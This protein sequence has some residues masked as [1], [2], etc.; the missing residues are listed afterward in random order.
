MFFS[1]VKALPI[2]TIDNGENSV[3]FDE[4]AES[5]AEKP[6]NVVYC[7]KNSM[8]FGIISTGDVH[9]AK[10]KGKSTVKVNTSFAYLCEGEYLK[11]RRIFHEDKRI[12]TLPILDEHNRLIGEHSRWDD[13]YS[14]YELKYLRGNRF[15]NVVLKRYNEVAIVAPSNNSDKKKKI[16]TEWVS[17][18]EEHDVRVE[19]ICKESVINCF[20]KKDIVFFFDENEMRGVGTLFKDVLNKD[21]RWNQVRTLRSIINAVEAVAEQTSEERI[22]R[23]FI[24]EGA[25]LFTIHINEKNSRY[26]KKFR[27]EIKT[28]YDSIGAEVNNTFHKEFRKNFYDDIYNEE[29]AFENSTREY[30]QI[31]S[32]GLIKLKDTQSKFYNVVGGERVT[33]GQPEGYNNTIWFFGPCFVIGAYVDDA[34]T[35]ESKLQDLICESG[36]QSRVVNCGSFSNKYQ[37]LLRLCSTE[38]RSGDIVIYHSYNQHRMIPYLDLGEMLE[39]Q[40]VSAKNFLNN[41]RHGNHK[42]YKL[43]A[44]EIYNY[45]PKYLFGSKAGDRI[46]KSKEKYEL[47]MAPYFE[48]FFKNYD[49]KEKTGAVVVNCNP[50]TYGHRYLIEEAS[51][52]V[53]VLIVFVVNEDASLF[54]FDERLAMVTEGT[55]DLSNVKVVPSGEFILSQHSFPEYF[56]KVVDDELTN[57]AEFDV[58]LFAKGVAPRLN[59]KYRFVGEEN[60]DET[61]REYNEAMKRILPL[62]GIEVIEIPRKKLEGKSYPIS[63]TIVRNRL[64]MGDWEGVKEFVP[65]STIS[66]IRCAD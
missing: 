32:D 27:D 14:F 4:I 31:F 56:N 61:T 23:A 37:S 54:S 39:Q 59:I 47:L 52:R 13:V 41:P 29:Y 17:L 44:E 25:Y 18:F 48:S 36:F 38:I 65:E 6:S 53:D 60:N 15:A 2:I 51:R 16:L 26:W 66:V 9:R 45:I 58:K 24:D 1:D 33:V 62:N 10:D 57:Y 49:I 46:D 50:F 22:L 12:N 30:D 7:Y 8:L 55:K 34:N 21:F 11:A 40:N 42:A 19:V 64:E 5:L 3:S 28:K 35:I 20:D 43:F 63:A